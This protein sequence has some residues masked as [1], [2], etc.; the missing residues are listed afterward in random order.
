M[1]GWLLPVAVLVTSVA[2]TY[3]F[4]LRPMRRGRC[5]SAPSRQ[6]ADADQLDADLA[7][8]R[9]QLD[10]LRADPETRPASKATPHV[11]R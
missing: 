9:I 11:Q 8:A 1:S 4:C 5:G 7:R 2:L 3:L 6:T 10:R